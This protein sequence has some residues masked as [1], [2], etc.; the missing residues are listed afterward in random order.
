MH[1]TI[2][3]RLILLV[4]TLVVLLCPRGAGQA[5][6][7]AADE[8]VPAQP[9]PAPP[10]PD[11]PAA[12]L[13]IVIKGDEIPKADK[14]HSGMVAGQWMSPRQIIL[15]AH[16]DDVLRNRTAEFAA[17]LGKADGRLGIGDYV[18][19]MNGAEMLD[20]VAEHGYQRF[21]GPVEIRKWRGGRTEVDVR[22][23]ALNGKSMIIT[24]S[25]DGN[26]QGCG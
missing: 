12:T 6:A 5:R 19:V 18:T 23:T 16:L 11:A 8:P 17:R 3:F 21:D 20:F 24:L 14:V 25:A 22:I 26:V 15:E 1:A 10:L 4:T 9:L 13:P 2:H 7:A